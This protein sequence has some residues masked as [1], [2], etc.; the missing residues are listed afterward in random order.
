M[1]VSLYWTE[2]KKN[3]EVKDYYEQALRNSTKRKKISNISTDP[4]I[5]F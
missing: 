2:H 5:I 1:L 4:N 3:P